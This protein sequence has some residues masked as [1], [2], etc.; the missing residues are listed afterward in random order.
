MVLVL[1]IITGIGSITYRFCEML[2]ATFL[3]SSSGT[4]VIT[5]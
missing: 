2:R 4:L 3:E 5:C 1:S